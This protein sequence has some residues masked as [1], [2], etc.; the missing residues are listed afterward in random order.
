MPYVR[1][2]KGSLVKDILVEWLLILAWL[3][4][5]CSWLLSCAVCATDGPASLICAS[6]LLIIVIDFKCSFAKAPYENPASV[7]L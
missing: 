2:S 3:H 7:L 1:R 5:F 6:C 4:A